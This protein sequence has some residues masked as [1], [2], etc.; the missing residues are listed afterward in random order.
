MRL[1]LLKRDLVRLDWEVKDQED[2]FDR[3]SAELLRAG[4]IK[5]SFCEALAERERKYPT[6][7]PT[8]PEAVA[9]PHSDVEHIVKPFIASVRLAR[10]IDWREMGND[11]VIHPVRF[12]FVLGFVQEDR[13]VEVLQIMLQAFQDPVFM[14]R[15]SEAQSPDEY[16]RVLSDMSGLEAA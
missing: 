13:H 12:I 14:E 1:D 7:L 4:Y 5:D 9:I 3:I 6:A 2:F 16:Y 8:S 15:L 10:P 11:D